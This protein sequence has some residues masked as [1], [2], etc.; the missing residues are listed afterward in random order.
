MSGSRCE[1]SAIVLCYRAGESI[2]AVIQPLQEL[3]ERSG[4]TYELVLVAN[5][6]P[7]DEDDTAEI[8]RRFADA[9]A[10]VNVLAS[11][12]EGGMGWDM[13]SG[14]AAAEGDYLIAIDGDAQNPVE[15]VLRLHELMRRSAADVGKGR[16]TNRA[17]GIYRR[18]I[19]WG[20]QRAAPCAF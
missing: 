11:V 20:F 5:Y 10:N 14:F 7:Q 6:W 13:R 1:V 8:V 2:A 3:L 15:D 19:S 17:D 9:H 18:V 12:K 4:L 16:R